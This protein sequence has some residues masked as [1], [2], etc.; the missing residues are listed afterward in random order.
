MSYFE[1]HPEWEVFVDKDYKQDFGEDF[2]EDLNRYIISFFDNNVG[3]RRGFSGVCC[4]DDC[5][6]YTRYR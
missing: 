6:S 4:T 5:S 1:T 3:Y 2:C